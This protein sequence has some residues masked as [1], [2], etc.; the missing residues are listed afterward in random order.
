MV[1]MT[2][3]DALPRDPVAPLLASGH[4]AVVHW[5]RE[6]LGEPIAGARAA[7]WDLPVPRRI[8]HRQAEDGSW[9]YPGRRA[10]GATDY[11]L[12]E[13]Y[14]ELGFLVEMFGLTRV[15]PAVRAAADYVLAH[16]SPDGDLRG[17]YGNQPSP[18]YTAGLLELLVKA[19]YADD[20]R[21]GRA[22]AWLEASR[23]DDG[24]WAIPFRTRGLNLE[25][26]GE[27]APA[28]RDPGRPS[29]HLVTGVVLRAYAAHPTHRAGPTTAAAARL[30]ASRLFEAD[31][32][33]DRGGAAMWTEFSY[34]FW[35]TD[36]VSALDS[37]SRIRAGLDDPR[38][39]AARTW[40][41]AHQ[42]PDGLFTGHLLKDR[43]HDLRLWFS[44]AVCRVLAR[45]G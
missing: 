10:R 24:G 11:D 32:Y 16:Q 9:T 36:I 31:V 5:T 25:A 30:L 35:F 29:S 6:L 20:P 13:T 15:H 23:Q 41:T 4:S 1:P 37:L 33:P 39:E 12:L 34:P 26:I 8:L 14:R 7:L 22:F 2:W 44:L 38:V 42:G 28:E 45:L 40:L 21:V 17:I 3:L 19:G 43:F 18:N 27:H